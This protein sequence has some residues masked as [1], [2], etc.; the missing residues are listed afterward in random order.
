[1]SAIEKKSFGN[2]VKPSAKQS[3]LTM[4][5]TKSSQQYK[6]MNF[7]TSNRDSGYTFSSLS[8]PVRRQSVDEKDLKIRQLKR[9]ILILK[10]KLKLYEHQSDSI[11]KVNE[12]KEQYLEQMVQSSKFGKALGCTRQNIN[13]LRRE[14]KVLAVSGK[15][16]NYYPMWQ[17]NENNTPYP[18]I[19]SIIDAIGFD[20]QWTIVQFFHSRFELIENKTP[21]EYLSKNPN[22]EL[23]IP[24]LAR[25][26]V[27][28]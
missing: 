4:E 21:I 14:H 1:M 13:R 11:E 3:R 9:Q 10:E 25:Q 19:A 27:A 18:C 17:L 20:N 23:K 6:A 2:K 15:N 7:Y 16:G 8:E 28:N 5:P 12:I 26:Y 24:K 22:D